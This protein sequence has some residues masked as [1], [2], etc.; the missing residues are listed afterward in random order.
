MKEIRT[1]LEQI[2]KAFKLGKVLSFRTE[3]YCVDGYNVAYFN[4]TQEQALKYIYK[5]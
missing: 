3:K 5:A 4:T 2:A 1:T